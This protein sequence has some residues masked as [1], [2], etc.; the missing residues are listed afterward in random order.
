MAERRPAEHDRGMVS[1]GTSG[2]DGLRTTVRLVAATLVATVV[3]VLVAVPAQAAPPAND[4]L[5]GASPLTTPGDL[6]VSNAEASVEPG[7][8]AAVPAICGAVGYSVWY[9]YQATSDQVIRVGTDLV[10]GQSSV[11]D[12]VLAVYTSSTPAT[13]TIASLSALRCSDDFAF[14][15][16]SSVEVEVTTGTTY[17]VQLG[18]DPAAGPPD[19]PVVLRLEQGQSPA[20]DDLAGAVALTPGT[21]AP[22]TTAFSTLEPQE[23]TSTTCGEV[24]SSIWYRWTPVST[25][26]GDLEVAN[27]FNNMS[28]VIGVYS[29]PAPTTSVTDLT[30][31][32]CSSAAAFVLGADATFDTTPG[33]TYYLQVADVGNQSDHQFQGPRTVTFA[34]GD[35]P[36]NDDLAD[37]IDTSSPATVAVDT[38]YAHLEPG[39]PQAAV[40]G[41]GA[42]R[43]RTTW[44]RYTPAASGELELRFTDLVRPGDEPVIFVYSGPPAGATF[45]QLTR[46]GCNGPGFLPRFRVPV[47]AGQTYYVQAGSFR[48]KAGYHL[49]LVSGT[50]TTVSAATPA[51][52]QVALDAAVSTVAGSLSGTVT[53]SE[54]LDLAT[55][56]P[57]A[58]V[59]LVGGHAGAT[60]SGVPPGHHVYRAT[61]EPSGPGY[62]SS[63]GADV[64]VEVAPTVTA[65]TLRIHAPRKVVRGR[66]ASV[67]VTVT[68]SDGGPASGT[69]A[70]RIAGRTVTTTL[71]DGQATIRTPRLRK[72][73]KVT[74]IAAY[75]ATTTTLASTSTAV[76]KVTRRR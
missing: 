26:G 66:S 53:F 23:P 15:P 34:V 76:I 22:A 45:P 47:T 63:T 68:R 19:V 25:T 32:D 2:G 72:T 73:G 5:A 30:L 39:E 35:P 51:T 12:S 27:G 29:A 57:V 69:V 49:Q 70:V 44:F 14:S 60:L 56:T 48:F 37:A 67:G 28:T 65:T 46:V 1:T 18:S 9:R 43:V 58:T 74:V 7:E 75:A 52:E 40:P 10:P 6:V 59:P 4:D 42:I 41:C 55:T 24:Y 38:T 61:F 31:V 3:A 17:F 71:V 8:A 62:T 11:P 13:P 33:T 64:S 20:N 50:T 21:A 36:V 16:N 54:V